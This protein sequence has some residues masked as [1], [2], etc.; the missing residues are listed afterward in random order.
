MA[1]YGR[2]LNFEA[3]IWD[4][5][6]LKFLRPTKR[7]FASAESA[8]AWLMDKI[9]E[10]PGAVEYG[11]DGL[12]ENGRPVVVFL[13]AAITE[14]MNREALDHCTIC[15]A[16][17]PKVISARHGALCEDCSEDLDGG[18]DL[19]H[20]AALTEAIFGEEQRYD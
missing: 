10:D 2:P 6:A 1:I 14:R 15:R 16:P 20:I 8:K 17:K 11:I 13:S 3:W 4:A 7:K 19:D 12:G 18:E 5:D 9:A